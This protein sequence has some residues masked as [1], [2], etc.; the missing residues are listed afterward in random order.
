[1]KKNA[2]AIACAAVIALVL[3]LP[4]GLAGLLRPQAAVTN[5]GATQDSGQSAS[6]QAVVPE[7][8]ET[9]AEASSDSSGNP[10]DEPEY[11]PGVVLVGISDDA[12]IDQVN[13]RLQQLDYVATKSISEEELLYGYAE[14]TLAEGVEVD[15]AVALLEAED[16]ATASQ[17]NYVYHLLD[18]EE[19]ESASDG[20]SSAAANADGPLVAQHIDMSTQATSINDPYGNQ[21]WGLTAIKAYDAWD[22]AKGNH[23]VTVAVLD[24][25][26]DMNH[27]DFAD[28]S[29][30]TNVVSPYS[31]LQAKE[32]GNTSN[33]ADALGHGTHVAGIISAGTNN[34]VGVAGV[35][36]NANIMPVQVIEY[37]YVDDDGKITNRVS[38]QPHRQSQERRSFGAGACYQREL[39]HHKL[40]YASF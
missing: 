10:P 37:P 27:P 33:V 26:L 8:Q 1:M 36:Y 39:R 13:E 18:T 17:P 14:I 29:N 21:Q 3:V 24:S 4:L 7:Q 38:S 22:N 19:V 2:I 30:K 34:G 16:F 32:H 40:L 6:A 9:P 25:G 20:A 31:V 15:D 35:S 23:K 12:S 28:A 11:I 5:Q